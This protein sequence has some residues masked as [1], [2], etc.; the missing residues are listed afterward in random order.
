MAARSLR[1]R[2]VH[3][4]IRNAT[5]LAEAV[6]ASH[7]AIPMLLGFVEACA[8]MS[9]SANCWVEADGTT[10]NLSGGIPIKH[11]AAR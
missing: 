10:G 8:R 4:Y 7:A 3:D 11:H 5:L 6:N 9:E 1:N 2:M